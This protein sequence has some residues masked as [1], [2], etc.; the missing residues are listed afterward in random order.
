MAALKLPRFEL[1]AFPMSSEF[2]PDCPVTELGHGFFLWAAAELIG[3]HTPG[4]SKVIHIKLKISVTSNQVISLVPIVI[5]A[6]TTEFAFQ[7]WRGHDL[8]KTVSIP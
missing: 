1:L 2:H 5:A 8:H 6:Q 4:F 3:L 7:M